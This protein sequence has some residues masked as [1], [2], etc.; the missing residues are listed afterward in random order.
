MRSILVS[1]VKYLSIYTQAIE[2]LA[3][4]QR[5]EG[6][7]NKSPNNLEDELE[8]N[9]RRKEELKREGRAL[10]KKNNELNITNW[11]NVKTYTETKQEIVKLKEKF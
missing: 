4:D 5:G 8:Y 11:N 1:I 10:D 3:L 9:I 2:T 6:T 7:G